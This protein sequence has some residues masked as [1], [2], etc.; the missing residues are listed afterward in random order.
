MWL[1]SAL[2]KVCATLLASVVIA[3]EGTSLDLHNP[4]RLEDLADGFFDL[5]VTLTP[6]AHCAV[7]EEMCNFS[8]DIEYWPRLTRPL[9]QAR[10]GRF[11]MRPALFAKC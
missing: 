1:P 8:V 11:L 6:Q 3:G 2:S 5:V 9:P 10:G 4:R 7:L